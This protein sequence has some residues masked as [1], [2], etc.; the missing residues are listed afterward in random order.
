MPRAAAKPA[1]KKS[2]PKKS[3]P[4]KTIK[5]A[6]KPKKSPIKP[7][8]ARNSTL[9]ETVTGQKGTLRPRSRLAK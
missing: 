2:A 1:A 9:A 7:T 6:T 3:A 8:L 4:K 5:K